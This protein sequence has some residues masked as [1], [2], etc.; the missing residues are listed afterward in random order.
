MSL[1]QEIISRHKNF[2]AEIARRAALV[3]QKEERTYSIPNAPFGVKKVNPML[4][5]KKEAPV[6]RE[7]LWWHCMWF[8]DLIAMRA[9]REPG[10]PPV[11]YIQAVVA[12][13][14]GVTK[15][16]LIS[17]R[18]TQNVVLP[19]Q[20]AMYLA[21]VMTTR[22]YP[23]IGRRFGGRDHT[24]VIHSVR[25][26]GARCVSDLEFAGKIESIKSELRA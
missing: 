24:T 13:H 22:S 1:E 8:A 17:E 6:N 16:D 18:R 4:P 14:F 10:P 23:E 2:H 7:P 25:K 21:K 5:V 19:R 15:T 26:V 20:I 9:P 11:G 12:R 3:P